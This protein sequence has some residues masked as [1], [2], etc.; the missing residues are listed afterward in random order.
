[1]DKKINL[2]HTIRNVVSESLG[3]GVTTDKFKGNQRAFL[4]PAPQIKP[5]VGD[6]HPDG[7][8]VTAKRGLAKINQSE[9]MKEEEQIDEAGGVNPKNSAKQKPLTDKE[10]EALNPYI[11]FGKD[12][13]PILGTIRQA[14]R[15]AEAGRET[16]KEW[17][18]GNYWA[19]A[20]GAAYTAGQGVLTGVSGVGDVLT[21]T[22]VGAP[23]VAVAKGVIKG[24]PKA[25]SS[26]ASTIKGVVAGSKA[27][28]A[29]EVATKA[30]AAATAKVT[31]AV[32]APETPRIDTSIM[33]NMDKI[34]VKG[35][36]ISQKDVNMG[37]ASNANK[38][39]Q[40]TE[41]A[42]VEPVPSPKKTAKDN[43]TANDQETF[44]FRQQDNLKRMPKR[45]QADIPPA[46]EK[47]DILDKIIKKKP[48]STNKPANENPPPLKPKDIG[49]D[50]PKFDEPANV[51][52]KKPSNDN[53]VKTAPAR[54]APA[55][56]PAEM[57]VPNKAADVAPAPAAT[58]APRKATDAEPAPRKAAEP[59]PAA[60]TKTAKEKSRG[61]GILP[62]SFGLPGIGASNVPGGES[63]RTKDVGT[64]MHRAGG[65]RPDRFAEEINLQDAEEIKRKTRKAQIIRK[66][67][68]EQKKK[69]ETS[70]VNL[71]PKLN[72][73]EA[74]KN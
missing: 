33:G 25:I 5:K 40:I 67:I 69:K 61:K 58:P 23:A 65:R 24:A 7:S 34:K 12:M 29:A 8:A 14:G 3:A 19:A 27:E 18:K 45:D 54:E 17:E 39:P 32:T 30:P 56:K 71:H 46:P 47:N 35:P 2:E 64:Y 38:P 73:Q 15:T 63:G 42:K 60:K 55:Y 41:P 28:K 21:A 57:P 31:P 48:E 49:K 51:N 13:T 74:D 26:L 4:Q 59:A 6:A 70:T 72:Q 10:K 16:A 43:K 36:N 44:D 68:D 62:P 22:G 11:E 52:V 20:K 9:T 37:A 1:M 50:K 66:I 53:V